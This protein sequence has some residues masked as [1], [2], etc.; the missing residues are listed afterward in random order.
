MRV[1]VPA[2]GASPGGRIVIQGTAGPGSTGS[3]ADRAVYGDGLAALLDLI[4]ERMPKSEVEAVWAFP[5]VRRE[6]REHGVV[7]VE[8]HLAESRRLVY[9]GRYALQLKGQ[10]RG[11]IAVDLEET[12]E[13][14]PEMV[15]RVIE[16]VRRRADEAG[17]AE[18]VDLGPWRA[19]GD[20]AG[21][22]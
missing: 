11:R 14:V 6:G 12:A 13:A 5:G 19:G 8:R 9:R 16:G 21:G 2:D 3:G 17:E 20:A 18:L 1:D 15:T 22:G 7:V 10:E 4:A